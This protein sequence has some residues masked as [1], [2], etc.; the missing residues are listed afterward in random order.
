MKNK[1]MFRVY[2]VYLLHQ[3]RNPVFSNSIVLLALALTLPIFVSVPSVFSNML[4]S[5]NLYNYF[6]MAFSKTDLAVQTIIILTLCSA[7][8]L[9]KHITFQTVS[10]QPA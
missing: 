10:R 4:N 7:V 5:G 6:L 9:A 8:F 2:I 1:I 3:L